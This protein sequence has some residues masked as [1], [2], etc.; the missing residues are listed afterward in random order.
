MINKICR[1]ISFRIEVFRYLRK[2]HFPIRD[3]RMMTNYIKNKAIEK[4]DIVSDELFSP[5]MKQVRKQERKLQRYFFNT[6]RRN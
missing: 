3:M 6:G 5:N 2:I 4:G 1:E